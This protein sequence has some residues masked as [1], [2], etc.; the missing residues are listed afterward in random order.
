MDMAKIEKRI[1]EIFSELFDANYSSG[2][3]KI[4]PHTHDGIDNLQI[5]AKNILGLSAFIKSSAGKGGSS[6]AGNDMDVQFNNA[7]VLAGDDNFIYDVNSTTVSMVNLADVGGGGLNIQPAGVLLVQSTGNAITIQAQGTNKDLTLQGYRDVII[8]AQ[9]RDLILQGVN[10][11]IIQATDSSGFIGMT[12][13][14][15]VQIN[16]TTGPLDLNVTNEGAPIRINY[17]TGQSIITLGPDDTNNNGEIKLDANSVILLKSRNTGRIYLHA[18]PTNAYTDNLGN[19]ILFM[20][21]ASTAPVNTPATGG[22]LYVDAGALKYKGSG[23][24]VTTIAPA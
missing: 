18:L 22:I 9:H 12:A 13:G 6:V 4:E 21:D 3:P 20:N 14:G 1:R 10:D 19:G 2:N 11:V 16:A 8:Q 24:T 5:P 15:N 7:G 17:G 23:G